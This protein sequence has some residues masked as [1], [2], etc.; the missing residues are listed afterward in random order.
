MT[1]GSPTEQPLSPEEALAAL[2][3]LRSNIVA[4]QTATWSNVAYPLVAILDAAGLERFEPTA[5][6]RE[7]HLSCYGGAGGYPGNIVNPGR[8]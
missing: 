5:E 2:N 3:E 8:R 7:Q 6:Q 4:T 1:S